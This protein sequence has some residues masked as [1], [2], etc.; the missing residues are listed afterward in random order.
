M[1]KSALAGEGAGGACPSP[2]SLL[3]SRSVRSSWEARYTPNI[4]SLPFHPLRIRHN[5]D[6][7]LSFFFFSQ[8]AEPVFVDPSRSPEI[9][10]QPGGPVRQPYFSYR[11]ARLH[12][13]AKSIPRNRFLGSINVYKYGLRMR[14][15]WLRT[16]AGA[17]STAPPATSSPTSAPSPFT[18][19]LS[20]FS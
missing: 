4:S 1:E 11:P 3:P 20:L 5:V 17:T 19:R 6:W 8:H 2:F 16:C 15:G 18:L 13:L 12:G 9:D 7:L 14:W 10:S